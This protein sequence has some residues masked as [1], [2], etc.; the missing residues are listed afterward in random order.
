MHLWGEH[1]DYR[2]RNGGITYGAVRGFYRHRV[3]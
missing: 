2:K 1:S 3:Q